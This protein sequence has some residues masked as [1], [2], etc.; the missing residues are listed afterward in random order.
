MTQDN[1]DIAD[2]QQESERFSAQIHNLRWCVCGLLRNPGFCTAAGAVYDR[3][4]FAS[5][6]ARCAVIDRAYSFA[7]PESGKKI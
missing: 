3:A 7:K 6:W 4:T 1:C 5:E 2:L